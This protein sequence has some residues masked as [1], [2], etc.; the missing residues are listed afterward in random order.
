MIGPILV[1]LDGS[2]FGEHAVS[3]AASLARRSGSELHLA[4]VHHVLP[5][6]TLEGV[7][8]FDVVD[9]HHREEEH[10]YLESLARKLA[11]THSLPVKIVLLDGEVGPALTEYAERMGVGLVVMSTHGR[12]AFGR[13]WLG[14]VTDN[15]LREMPRPV[16]LIRPD[17]TQ[18]D[19]SRD[20]SLRTIL[21]PLDGSE[22]AEQI[23]PPVIELA[24]SFDSAVEMVRVVA[25]VAPPTYLNEG[26]ALTGITSESI[27]DL[28]TLQLQRQEDAQTYLDRMAERIAGSGCRVKSTVVV[29][30][31]PARAILD[32]AHRGHVDLI[33]MESHGRRGLSRLFLGSVAD[34]IVRAAEVPVLLHRK[35]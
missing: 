33:A 35:K 32:E 34:K 8:V 29:H 25:P 2:S 16:A 14:S 9:Q 20:Y 1:P 23:L 17:D 26:I 7:S 10:A 18:V 11:Q 3:L 4:H 31:N 28:R 13:F 5:P 19:L 22:L 24:K 27:E 21:L 30:E 15:V 12:G 6:A